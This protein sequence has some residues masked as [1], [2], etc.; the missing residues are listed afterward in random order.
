METIVSIITPCYNSEA[1]IAQAIESVLNQTYQNWEMLIC[2]DCSTDRSKEI[3]LKYLMYEEKVKSTDYQGYYYKVNESSAMHITTIKSL[4][5]FEASERT[6]KL[7]CEKGFTDNPY[8]TLFPLVQPTLFHVS[9]ERNSSIYEYI[10][11]NMKC[12]T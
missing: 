5:G 11:Q 6:G 2:D 4:T 1:Y 9:I 12:A 10:H 8:I 7:L 3:M